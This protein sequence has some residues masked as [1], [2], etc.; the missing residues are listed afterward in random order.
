MSTSAIERKAD[1]QHFRKTLFVYLTLSVVAIA[2]NLIY[3]LFGHSV[4]AAAMILMF[5][6]SAFVSPRFA[7][8]PGIG[9][10]TTRTI[11]EL[12]R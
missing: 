1:R 3:G 2:I 8:F 6:C 4:H 12:P 9:Y 5:L 11:P 10:A 7:A